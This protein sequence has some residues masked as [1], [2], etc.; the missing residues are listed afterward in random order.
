MKRLVRVREF[1]SLRGWWDL[2]ADFIHSLFGLDYARGVLAAS[3]GLRGLETFVQLLA[4]ALLLPAAAPSVTWPAG[5]GALR[6]HSEIHEE[7][8]HDEHA[9]CDPYFWNAKS[10]VINQSASC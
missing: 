1:S 8:D 2:L 4:V 3:E 10:D 6:V 5:S 7:E 9:Q